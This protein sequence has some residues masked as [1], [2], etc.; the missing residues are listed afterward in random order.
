MT[1]APSPSNSNLQLIKLAKY[2]N[3][4]CTHVHRQDSFVKQ[5]KN[6][7]KQSAGVLAAQST[8][9]HVS[10]SSAYRSFNVAANSETALQAPETLVPQRPAE[11][12]G[13]EKVPGETGLPL[14]H[15]VSMVW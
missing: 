4:P 12:G 13:W 15:W 1:T 2:Q 5:N 11:T 3:P 14:C 8:Q 9:T 7:E 6:D 10:Q